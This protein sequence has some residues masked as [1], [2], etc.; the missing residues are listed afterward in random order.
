M[1]RSRRSA[2]DSGALS[3]GRPPL[4]VRPA[5]LPMS[6]HAGWDDLAAWW[7]A[8]YKVSTQ[9]T[10]ACHL[11]RWTAWCVGRG[12]NP[13]QAGRADVELWLHSVAGSGLSRA[14][15]A[16]HYDAVASIYPLA[17]DEDLIAINPCARIARPKVLRELQRRDVLTVLEYAALPHRR[18]RAR[19]NPSRHR[20][21]RRHAG[22]AR[23]R[24]GRPDRRL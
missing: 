16:G 23:Q 7:L 18:P 14:S 20:R 12:L 10:Y 24:D 3:Q 17:F 4:R 8:R 2:Q 22:A 9:Q 6:G 5:V 13:L 1:R 15:T 21:P 19:T 11:P